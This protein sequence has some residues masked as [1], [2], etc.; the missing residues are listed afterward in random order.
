MDSLFHQPGKNRI[1]Q[2]HEEIIDP[3]SKIQYKMAHESTAFY[4]N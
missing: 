3:E 4:L 2:R 1:Y